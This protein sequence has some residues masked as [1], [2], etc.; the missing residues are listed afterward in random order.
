F[1]PR[2]RRVPAMMDLKNPI[3]LGPV[4]NQEHHMNG[5]VARRNH[6]NEPILGLLEQAY[7]EFGRLTGRF[8]GL[9]AEYRT[10]DDNCMKCA[11][12]GPPRR[13]YPTGWQNWYAAIRSVP[14]CR[15]RRPVCSRRNCAASAL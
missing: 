15:T 7:A 5:V 1:G 8:Y 4:Q 13:T 6:F 3:L 14:C 11:R 2:R 9:L 12:S 10:E